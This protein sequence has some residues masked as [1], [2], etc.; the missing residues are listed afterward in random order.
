ME[1][2]NKNGK[3]ILDASISF[4]EPEEVSL[5]GDPDKAPGS[6]GFILAFYQKT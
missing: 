5:Q 4:K 2:L 3:N 6:D 1:V